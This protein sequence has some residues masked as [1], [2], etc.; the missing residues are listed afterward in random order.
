MILSDGVVL[1]IFLTYL[2]MEFIKLLH[3]KLKDKFPLFVIL[4]VVGAVVI[5]VLNEFNML[6]G[7]LKHCI[8]D[9]LATVFVS[10]GIY[11]GIKNITKFVKRK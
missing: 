8:W 10:S 11:G 1:A 2:A 5:F 3:I 4:L 7:D 9:Y 6:R